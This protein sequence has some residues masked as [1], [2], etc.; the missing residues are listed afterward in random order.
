MAF[1]AR[2]SLV[3]A[4]RSADEPVV[5]EDSSFCTHAR[6]PLNLNLQPA[7]SCLTDKIPL[8]RSCRLPFASI[9]A[10][11][12]KSD[13]RTGMLSKAPDLWQD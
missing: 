4:A 3:I 11:G 2:R 13:S 6:G 5:Q 7:V 12:S 8:R 9:T 1:H 10:A